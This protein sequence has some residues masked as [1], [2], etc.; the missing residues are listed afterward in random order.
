MKSAVETLNPTRVKLIVEV[1]FEELKPSLDAAY[2]RISQQI[3]IPGF[4]RG[5]VPAMVIDQRIGRDVV[6]DEAV[7]EAL[8]KLFSQALQ[9]NDLMPLSQPEVDLDEVR[10]GAELS[11]TA[12][13][14][15]KPQ[16][17][18]PDYSA[19]EV[20]V[21]DVTVGDDEVDE[22]VEL[23]RERFGS[24]R[25]V[26]RPAG[27]GDF[28]TLDLSAAHD[29]E[30]IEEAQATGMSYRVGRGTLLD[31]LDEALP[32]MSAGDEK[33]FTSTLAAGEFT[34]QPVDVTVKV[35][36]VQEQE[37]PD[38]DDDFAQQASEFD[39]IDE[40]RADLSDRLT[41]GARI[42]QASAARDAVLQA[43]LTRVDI[44]L[45][46]SAVAA[47]LKA[48]RDSVDEQ[49][50]YAGMTEADYL[51]SLGQSEEEYAAELEQRVRDAMVAQ[52][53]LDE[54]AVAE[55]V[56]VAEDDLS[57]H[58][59]RRAQQAGVKPEQYVQHVTE[60]NQVPEL[61]AEIRRGKAL[62]QVVETSVV[63]D[64]SGNRVELKRLLPDGTYAE[65]AEEAEVDDDVSGEP[66]AD[67]GLPAVQSVDAAAAV[68][69]S[70]D[71]LVEGDAPAPE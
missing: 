22:Q 50:T 40:L 71:Y 41:R 42:E 2:K 17:Q 14:D 68:I 69:G 54:I 63:T 39:T 25:P 52:F 29:G 35:T 4:R 51:E 8:P 48:R 9:D 27:D 45:P 1:P 59:L 20:Q 38:L 60:H 26:D 67:P 23:L 56:A 21:D 57:Q 6:L 3:T 19:L 15:V 62:A 5:K 46:D 30:A 44:P 70:T 58:L 31:G 11:F 55:S 37:L 13:L 16:I 10:D 24:L 64:A 32:G 36:A 33:T 12:E 61:V 47:E 18:L 49:L 66:A 65:V 28:V 43:L 7:N 34:D 53:L